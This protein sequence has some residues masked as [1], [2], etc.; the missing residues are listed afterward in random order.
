MLNEGRAGAKKPRKE[1]LEDKL[2]HT[3]K[4]VCYKS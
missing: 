1:G 3:E 2:M 4:A